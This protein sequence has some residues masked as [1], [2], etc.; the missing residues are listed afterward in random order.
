M[1]P[2]LIYHHNLIGHEINESLT[3]FADDMSDREIYCRKNHKIM[4]PLKTDCED[5]PCFAGFEQGHGHECAWNDVVAE[6]HV[7][8]HEDRFKE[9]KRVDQ[10]LKS[11]ILNNNPIENK[12]VEMLAEEAMEY[13]KTVIEMSEEEE[14]EDDAE[15]GYFQEEDD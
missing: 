5:C 4:E 10:L 12:T 14:I 7:V 13:L 8:V 11:G 2:K 9:Y 6:E 15:H 1:E 3:F